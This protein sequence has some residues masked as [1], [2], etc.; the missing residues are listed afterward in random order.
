[1][2]KRIGILKT[3]KNHK[4]TDEHETKLEYIDF[5]SVGES[6]ENDM[7]ITRYYRSYKHL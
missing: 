3:L 2:S 1:M 4:I 5:E 6:V 7:V